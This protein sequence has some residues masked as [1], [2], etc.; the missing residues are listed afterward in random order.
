MI[1]DF[2]ARLALSQLHINPMHTYIKGHHKCNNNHL[3]R[4]IAPY[5]CTKE[6]FAYLCNPKTNMVPIVQLVRASD[7]GSE[8][9]GFESHW[10]P[11]Q[12]P[13]NNLI[14]KDFSFYIFSVKDGAARTDK[15]LKPK[16]HKTISYRGQQ[17]A[18]KNVARWQIGQG[19]MRQRQNGLNIGRILNRIA[20][21]EH[22]VKIRRVF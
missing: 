22:S 3:S 9:R 10:A 13:W 8:C 2:K 15:F 11:S 18:T 21:G 16:S 4:K 12:S 19:K 1:C 14:L 7:C 20:F 5:Y 6:N 17:A